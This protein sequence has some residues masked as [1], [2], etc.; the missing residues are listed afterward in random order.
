[1][2][3]GKFAPIVI[4]LVC[5]PLF[6]SLNQATEECTKEQKKELIKQCDSHIK[7][8]IPLVTLP[9]NST[10]CAEVTK[11]GDK[12]ILCICD[13]IMK[14]EDKKTY[15]PDRVLRLLWRCEHAKAF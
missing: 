9:R 8:G 14:S 12:H 13:L 11:L 10:C 1:M 5:T 7:R 3:F 6:T 2:L 15:D 4:L